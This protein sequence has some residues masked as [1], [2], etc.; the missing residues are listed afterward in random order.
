VFLTLVIV[1]LLALASWLVGR[2]VLTIAAV[3]QASWI[4]P[5]CGFA[6]LLCVSA[7]TIHLPGRAYTALA[8][9]LVIV[10][11]AVLFTRRRRIAWVAPGAPA[12]AVAAGLTAALMC[13]PFAVN[14]RFGL[15]GQ[16]VGD[17][18]G[19]HY[20]LVASLQKGFTLPTPPHSSGYPIGLHSLV[21]ATS[22][23]IGDINEAFTAVVILIPVLAAI[24]AVGF[25]RDQPPV[26]RTLAGTLV[27]LPY[28]TA[29]F[30]AQNAFKEMA[31]GLFVLGLAIALA[32]ATARRSPRAALTLGVLAAGAVQVT[33]YPAIAWAAGGAAIWALMTLAAERRLPRRADAR[34]LAAPLAW[35]AGAL[36]LLL[37]PSIGR[38]VAFDPVNAASGGNP[39]FL[40]YYFHNISAF[41][42]LGAWPIGDF[43]YF[44]TITNSFYIGILE[45]A[46][47]LLFVICLGWWLRDRRR[48][49]IPAVL[50]AAALI[51]A[52]AR[53]T[54]GPY[55]NAKPLAAIAP[56]AMLTMLAPLLAVARE[57]TIASLDGVAARAALLGFAALA[58]YCTLDVLDDARVGPLEH[59]ADL[60]RLRPAVQ[61]RSTLFL[62]EDHYVTWELAGAKLSVPT[63]WSIPSDVPV[64]PRKVVVGAPADFDSVDPATLD[65]FEYVVAART[66]SQSQAPAN[67]RPVAQ[68][69]WYELFKRVGPTAPRSI[70]EPAGE[71]GAILDCRTPAGAN[72]SR[73]HGVAGVRTPPVYGPGWSIAP[74]GTP[75]IIASSGRSVSQQLTLAPG[76]NE[77][78]L[79]YQSQVPMTL[80]LSSGQKLH[81]PAYLGAYAQLWRVGEVTVPGGPVTATVTLD[82][83][84]IEV[85]GRTAILGLLAA[86]PPGAADSEVP[87]ARACGR[88]VDWYRAG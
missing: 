23:A 45:G 20:A 86:S 74:P 40:G 52:Y 80:T 34:K 30:Y 25:L 73:A 44:P 36:G 77:I 38:V 43:R 24:A 69:R 78:S 76:R 35:A 88:Y 18:L 2:A 42:A 41:E 46:V 59:V 54:Q 19:A 3:E 32:E 81:I 84:P 11:A 10:A 71:P 68:T 51:Y 64:T 70:I 47:A 63:V 39:H 26:R 17:D 85:V 14:G 55:V 65:H 79:Q 72:L 6:L 87:L 8:C 33:G 1:L 5:V 4:G 58:A 31:D 37:L 56:L 50:A 57:R 13:I 22:M 67:F 48:F 82:R 12:A 15:I 60:M 62:P 16:S 28:L 49:A 21:A 7:G 75:A 61:N 27:A 66:A 29:A 9:V 83:A 53:H